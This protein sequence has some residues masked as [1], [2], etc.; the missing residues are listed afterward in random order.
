MEFLLYSFSNKAWTVI[1]NLFTRM[2]G[3]IGIVMYTPDILVFD[4]SHI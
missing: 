3:N 1:N 4:L 2:L